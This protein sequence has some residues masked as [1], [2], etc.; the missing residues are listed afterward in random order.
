LR[1]IK[2]AQRL[3]FTLGEVADLLRMG[4]HRHGKQVEPGLQ[5]Q[6][7]IKLAEVEA[8]IEDLTTIRTNLL[9]A[10]DAGCDDLNICAT[11]ECCPLPF[12]DLASFH[13]GGAPA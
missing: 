10:L 12:V 4:Q 6:A 3:G 2:A 7:R 5:A 8:R 9:T 13:E 11:T 1:V